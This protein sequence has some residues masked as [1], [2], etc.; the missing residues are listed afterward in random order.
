ME[1]FFDEYPYSKLKLD[2]MDYE[3]KEE[4]KEIKTDKDRINKLINMV[5]KTRDMMLFD[6]DTVKEKIDEFELY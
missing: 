1:D 6:I 5:Y 2:Y 4:P 3:I